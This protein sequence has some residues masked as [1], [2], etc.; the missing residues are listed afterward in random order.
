MRVW[1]SGAASVRI[2]RSRSVSASKESAETTSSR[3]RKGTRRPRKSSPSSR[4]IC[5]ALMAMAFF[6][7]KRAGL[8]FTSKMSKAWAISSMEKISRSAAIDQPSRAR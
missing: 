8:G 5:S 7:S 2:S 3:C 4:R 1:M 6:W